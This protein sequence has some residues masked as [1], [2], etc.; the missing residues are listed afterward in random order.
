VPG[1]ANRTTCDRPRLKGRGLMIRLR[2]AALLMLSATVC[3][4]LPV[5]VSRT[6]SPARTVSY[7]TVK[8]TVFFAPLFV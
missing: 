7:L 1:R 3:S 4:I 6:L 5:L 8:V 2:M